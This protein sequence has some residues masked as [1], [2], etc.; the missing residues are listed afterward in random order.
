MFTTL[1][2]ANYVFSVTQLGFYRDLSRGTRLDGCVKC[3]PGRWGSEPYSTSSKCNGACPRGTYLDRPGGRSVND[4]VKC[5]AGTYGDHTGLASRE[6]SGRC[7]DLNTA[8]TKYY[9]R[10]AGL[11]SKSDCKV[12]PEHAFF[13]ANGQCDDRE[14]FNQKYGLL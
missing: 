7:S 3:P 10:S 1:P 11:T 4:C 9:S 6:C 2:H 5:P 8:K 13:F 12:C 14:A